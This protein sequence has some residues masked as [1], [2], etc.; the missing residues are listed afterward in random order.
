MQGCS[1]TVNLIEPT[2]TTPSQ[3][4]KV[5]FALVRGCL[6]TSNLSDSSGWFKHIEPHRT[7]TTTISRC[8]LC[9]CTSSG[10][11]K[12]IE[13]YRTYTNH[14]SRAS[15]VCVGCLGTSSGWFKNIEPQSNLWRLTFYYARAQLL[16]R[17]PGWFKHSEPHRTY[18]SHTSTEIARCVGYL[19]TCSPLPNLLYGLPCNDVHREGLV[20]SNHPELVRQTSPR[21]TT[22]VKVCFVQVRCARPI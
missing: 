22:R 2:L 6:S 21:R 11:F 8:V 12:H 4:C 14:T 20:V 9:L 18:T 13:P 10:L 15:K 3:V 7:Y 5:L 19:F 1:S 17:P 16:G